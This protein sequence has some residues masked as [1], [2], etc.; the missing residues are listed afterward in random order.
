[1]KDRSNKRQLKVL[2]RLLHCYPQE[3][4]PKLLFFIVSCNMIYDKQPQINHNLKDTINT[5][6][7]NMKGTM[8]SEAA[9]YL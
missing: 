4:Y 6:N 9:I 8:V 2:L 7:I 1:M 5:T 3:L